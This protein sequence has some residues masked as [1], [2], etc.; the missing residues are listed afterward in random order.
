MRQT[1]FRTRRGRGFA[2]QRAAI[3]EWDNRSVQ[4]IAVKHLPP[5]RRIAASACRS[6][7]LPRQTHLTTQRED[8]TMAG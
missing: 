7:F 6:Y 3:A 1:G 8:N 5:Y 4:P 2:D